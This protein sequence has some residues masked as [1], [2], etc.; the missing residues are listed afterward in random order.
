MGVWTL[1]AAIPQVVAPAVTAP[2]VAYFDA[3]Q[4]GAGP[5]SALLLVALEF[6]AGASVLAALP[7]LKAPQPLARLPDQLVDGHR[8][9]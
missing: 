1:A 3:R 2:L 4:A 7:A 6:V 9:R 8:P 5:R